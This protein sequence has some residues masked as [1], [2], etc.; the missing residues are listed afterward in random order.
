MLDGKSLQS[1]TSHYLGK[2]FAS[3][4]EIKYLD[5]DGKLKNPYQ[6]SWGV[7]TRLIGALI[8]AHGD[9]RGLK[10]PPRV[11]PVQVVVIPVA[12]HKEGVIEKA[13]ELASVLKAAGIR[14]E[15]DERDQSVGW[16]FN[17]WEMK[18]APLRLEIGPRDIE[19]G[20][21][22]FSRRDTHEKGTISLADVAEKVPALLDD[23]HETMFRQSSDFLHSHIVTCHNMDEFTEALDKQCFVKA[24]WC[25]CR[26]C[27]D[28]IKAETAASARA[29]ALRPDADRRHLCLLREAC[30]AHR[31]LRQKLLSAQFRELLCQSPCRRCSRTFVYAPPLGRGS[32]AHFIEI[33]RSVY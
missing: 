13:R 25:G 10:L 22:V 29:I 9:Q 6:T 12:Q 28:A 17:E 8:M 16:K 27:E 20:V 7:S 11:A 2:N 14:V 15:T 32:F 1:G 3:A 33:S 31:G 4:F 26:E 30:Q 18:G 24:M 19:N 21:C 5:R 23:I